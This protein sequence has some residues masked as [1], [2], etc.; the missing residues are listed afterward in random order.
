MIS[1]LGEYRLSGTGAALCRLAALLAA[2]ALSQLTAADIGKMQSAL[3]RHGGS[4]A[5]FGEWRQLIDDSQRLEPKDKLRR[6]NEFFNRKIQSAD[7]LQ[8]W[9]QTDYWATPLETL[10]KARGDCEDFSIAKYFTLIESGMPN[11]QLRLIY[12]KA[13]IGGPASNISQAHMVLAYYAAPDAEPLILDN[14]ITD[15]RPASRRPDLLPVFSFNSLG[16]WAGAVASGA[17]WAAGVGRL[18]RWQDLLARARAEG[19]EF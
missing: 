6:I 11:E 3:Q 12:V 5:V 15:I 1:Q 16:F 14:L 2:F 10:A 17:P 7:D 13:R 19:I 4:A 9:G 8:V 18:T